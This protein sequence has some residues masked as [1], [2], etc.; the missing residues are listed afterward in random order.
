MATIH[1]LSNIKKESAVRF[2]SMFHM[3]LV[4]LFLW[5]APVLLVF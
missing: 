5:S 1:P 2:D 3:H 4:Q